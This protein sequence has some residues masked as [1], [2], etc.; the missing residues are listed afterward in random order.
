MT[1]K[2]AALLSGL[3]A[4]VL[5]AL[6]PTVHTPAQGASGVLISAVTPNRGAS[7]ANIL[8]VISGSD[9]PTADDCPGPIIE[10]LFDQTS[11]FPLE[12]PTRTQVKVIPPPHA[13]GPVDIT[14]RNLCDQ[15]TA[16]LKGG[17]TYT[18]PELIGGSIPKAGGFGLFVFGGGSNEDLL[19]ASGCPKETATF[20]ATNASGQ[21]V[22]YI[23][24]AGVQA[25]NNA[26][27]QL[28]P[29]AI[30]YRTALI[31]RCV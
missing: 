26:W 20:W 12:I 13:A 21:F 14:V 8:V 2:R 10:V 25:V 9:F 24:G 18:T 28:F 31:G 30:P 15:S 22:T 7:G 6:A 3:V 16:I 17:Y 19:K 23:P 27:N 29:N 5:L 4:L 1:R 11:A